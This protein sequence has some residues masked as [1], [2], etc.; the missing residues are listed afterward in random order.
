MFYLPL[1]EEGN[2]TEEKF[3]DQ[4]TRYSRA[5]ERIAVMIGM[6]D[7]YSSGRLP[8]YVESIKEI[9]TDVGIGSKELWETM[10][11]IFQS[12]RRNNAMDD[13]TRQIAEYKM[14]LV[15]DFSQF[16]QDTKRLKFQDWQGY[17]G[18]I[19]NLE[20]REEENK[21]IREHIAETFNKTTNSV[22][23]VHNFLKTKEP[24]LG[25]S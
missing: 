3:N 13:V 18:M 23:P 25:E 17:R 15:V 5:F 11:R 24:E 10:G 19:T 2:L 21:K 22:D 12:R 6:T 20:R 9:A 14:H 16:A 7:H 1:F 4:I 8:T